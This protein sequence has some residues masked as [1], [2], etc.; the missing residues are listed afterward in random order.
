MVSRLLKIVFA[1]E[2]QNM[3]QP[4]RTY[5]H[6]KAFNAKFTQATTLFGYSNA[7][8]DRDTKETTQSEGKRT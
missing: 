7:P 8:G 3:K 2:N 4:T 5:K 1:I 6:A